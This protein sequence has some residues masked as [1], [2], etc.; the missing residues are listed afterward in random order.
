MV[1]GSTTGPRILLLAQAGPVDAEIR[2]E[3]NDD[4]ARGYF[5]FEARRRSVVDDTIREIIADI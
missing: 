4:L 2:I 5:D 1:A 3:T